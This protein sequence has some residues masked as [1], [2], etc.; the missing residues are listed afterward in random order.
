[1]EYVFNSEIKP[2]SKEGRGSDDCLQLS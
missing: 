2:I 1:L